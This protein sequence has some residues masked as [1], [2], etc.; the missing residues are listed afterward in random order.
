[1]LALSDFNF[2]M[3]VSSYSTVKSDDRLASAVA[4]LQSEVTSREVQRANSLSESGKRPLFR[5]CAEIAF[6]V[7]GHL[8]CVVLLHVSLF[9]IIDVIAITTITF[10]FVQGQGYYNICISNVLRNCS[11]RFR[12]GAQGARAP[13]SGK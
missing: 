1:M 7:T 8:D 10:C 3:A 2:L 5:R 13:P 9:M 6:A 12:G 11:G 4:A